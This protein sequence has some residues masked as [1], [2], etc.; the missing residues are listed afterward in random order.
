MALKPR[1]NRSR[2]R[3]RLY[4]C[5]RTR[6]YARRLSFSLSLSEALPGKELCQRQDTNLTKYIPEADSQIRNRRWS[7]DNNIYQRPRSTLRPHASPRSSFLPRFWRT[8]PSTREPRARW[9]HNEARA[10]HFNRSDGYF[11]VDENREK[12]KSLLALLSY[13]YRK[14]EPRSKSSYEKDTRSALATTMFISTAAD[15]Y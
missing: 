14:I 15:V 8:Q 9:G 5:V 13:S 7:R 2:H 11:L 1:I 12:S 4:P 10:L 6:V 3:I